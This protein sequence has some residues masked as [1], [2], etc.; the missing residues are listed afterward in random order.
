[1]WKTKAAF[2][3]SR[4]GQW[5]GDSGPTTNDAVPIQADAGVPPPERYAAAFESFTAKSGPR[6]LAIS[7]RLG[8]VNLIDRKIPV[9]GRQLP[10][11]V[12]LML[13]SRRIREQGVGDLILMP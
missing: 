11:T 5:V 2:D 13:A 9:V 12:L 4:T 10:T 8:R 6:H 7:A 3:A 1:M